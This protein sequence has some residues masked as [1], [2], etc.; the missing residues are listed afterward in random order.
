V[1]ALTVRFAVLVPPFAV[2]ETV[3]VVFAETFTV[4]TGNVA[5]VV[6]ASTFTDAGIDPTAELPAVTANA[7]VVSVGTAAPNVTVPVL[8]CP[9]VTELGEK[10]SA[11]GMFAV[12]VKVPFTV[13]P[14]K[15]AEIFG[16]VDTLTALV[17]TVKLPVELPEGTTT[18]AGR[19]EIAVPPLTIARFTVVSC[20]AGAARVTVPVV[21]PPPTNV[22]GLNASLLGISGV[23]VS[24]GA[25]E[26]L[27]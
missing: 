23:I 27:L 10:V 7:T 19:D 21:E 22:L 8:L 11:L 4:V 24:T 20:A 1:F 5:D 14:F 25:I 6:P 15:L 18:E 9:A 17:T 2:A 13:V 16:V 12:T 3:T 26:A